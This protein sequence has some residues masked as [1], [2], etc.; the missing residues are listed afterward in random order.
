VIRVKPGDLIAVSEAGRY[1]YA[2]V[3]DRIRL[4]GGNWVFAFHTSSDQPVSADSLLGDTPSGFNAFVDF[5]FAKREGRLTRIAKGVP[6]DRF[7]GPGFLKSSFTIVGKAAEW[8]IA[9]MAFEDIRRV[10]ELDS[11]EREYPL[12]QRIDDSTMIERI[13][14]QWTP[15]KDARI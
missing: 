13:R 1:Y 12:R 15:G 2:L 5:I 4:F 9:N 8:H 3:L 14:D 7:Q 10:R 11:D 6:T